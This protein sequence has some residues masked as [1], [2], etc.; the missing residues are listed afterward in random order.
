MWTLE[1]HACEHA[2]TQTCVNM[3]LKGSVQW[4]YTWNGPLDRH[5]STN[6]DCTFGIIRRYSSLTVWFP[7]W[8]RGKWMRSC[9]VSSS[10]VYLILSRD[11]TKSVRDQRVENKQ[12]WTLKLQKG[13]FYEW[14]PTVPDNISLKNR[15]T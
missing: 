9:C 13:I 4:K 15:L 5:C 2:I 7:G 8:R 12:L 6:T 10:F 11:C 1:R 3:P 14:R